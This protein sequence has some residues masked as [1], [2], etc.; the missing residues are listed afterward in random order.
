M[1]EI[2]SS[3]VDFLNRYG[4]SFWD[5]AGAMLVQVTIL[6]VVLLAL[7]LLLRNRVR[8][9][10]RYWLWLLVLVKLVLPVG[11]HSPASIAYWL[12]PS[13]LQPE[14]APIAV[15]RGPTTPLVAHPREFATSA[16]ELEATSSGAESI[17]FD[18]RLEHPGAAPTTQLAPAVQPEREMPHLKWRGALFGLWI[19]G[20]LSLLTLVVRRALCVRR[21]VSQA[22]PASN[23]LQRQLL[24]CWFA[25]GMASHGARSPSP[26]TGEGRGEGDCAS[27]RRRVTV[28]MS[29]QL[30]SPA[31]CGLWRPTIL[32]P[33]GFPAGLDREQIQLVFVHELLHWRRGDLAVNSTQTLLQIVYFYN[34]AVWLANLIIRRLR[35]QAVDEAVLVIHRSQ[36]NLYASTLLDIAAAPL[37][38][39][40][41]AIGFTGV[42]ESR[43]ALATRIRR[44]VTRPIPRTAKL[45]SI[46]AVA[47]AISGV[48]LVPMG[49][50]D[51]TALAGDESSRKTDGSQ[52]PGNAQAPGDPTTRTAAAAPGKDIDGDPLPPGAI[53][54]LGSKRFRTSTQPIALGFQADGT[55]LAQITRG[56][57]SARLQHWNPTTG[58]LLRETRL[59]DGASPQAAA[60]ALT[61]NLVATSSWSVDAANNVTNH[62]EVFDATSGSKK[63]ELKVPDRPIGKLA[64]SHDGRTI[65]FGERKLH[66]VEIASQ[67]V[68]ESRDVGFSR[69][70][71]L[72]FSAD[73]SRLVVCGPGKLLILKLQSKDEPQKISIAHDSRSSSWGIDA[74]GFSPDGHML[75]VGNND[76]GPNGL[77]LFNTTN[78]QLVKSF[79]VPGVVS[80]YARAVQFSS[81]GRLLAAGISQDYGRGV[82]IIDAASGKLIH[83]LGGLFGDAYCLAFSPDGRKLAASSEWD[84]TMCVWD[85]TSGKRLGDAESTHDVPPSTIRFLADDRQVATASHDYT[86]RVWNVADSRQVQIMRHVR[87][88]KTYDSGIRGMDASPDGKYI[89]SSSYDDTVRLW[90]T[91][92]GREIYRLPGHGHLGGYRSVRF[93][94][95]GKQFASWGDD[96][97]RVNVWDVRTGKAVHE[98]LAHPGGLNMER[99]GLGNPPFSGPGGMLSAAAISR[100]AGTL[101]LLLDGLRRFSIPSGEELPWWGFK[102]GIGD[103][104]AISNDNRHLLSA[105]WGVRS[106][107]GGQ[108]EAE[109]HAVELRTLADGKMLTHIDVDGPGAGPMAFSPDGRLAAIVAIG[110]KNRI[111]LRKIPELSEIARIELPSRAW[112]VEFSHSGKLLA[113]S[114]ADSTVLVWDVENASSAVQAISLSVSSSPAIR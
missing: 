105:I 14:F 1:R 28:K 67:K 32:L 107:P 102:G 55:M 12:R 110:E 85:V 60:F 94:P 111:E 31:I 79:A 87:E 91:A 10:V 8:A 58:R 37:K 49:R 15:D 9:V 19:L 59:S 84:S 26:S 88:P 64:L 43:R 63:L 50:P 47:I 4:Q 81:D 42:V 22:T 78:R 56:A 21:I 11:I 17:P 62:V 66:I 74:A 99:D 57:S 44:I 89:A 23:E 83:R 16:D 75:V 35:E 113:V 13:R 76:C 7:E 30:G 109:K 93:T 71:S 5:F 46:G 34:P 45:G 53:A 92:T 54:R 77:L 90:E 97:M 73:D 98:F 61:A 86:V 70:S 6:V 41:A 103:Q 112:G 3:G 2:L 38:P 114:V 25:L 39:I 96:D 69:I 95:D 100:D 106:V 101:V 40:E 48:L 104:I 72:S 36:P 33:R 52:K 18:G 82:A 27:D 108:R 68:L 65:A 29:E 24:D 80:W 51:S 20:A